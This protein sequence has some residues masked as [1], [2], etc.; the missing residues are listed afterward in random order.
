MPCR[1]VGNHCK[2]L[3]QYTLV[4]SAGERRLIEHAEENSKNNWILEGE[5]W[6]V[7]SIYSD[8]KYCELD[9]KVSLNSSEINIMN[10]KDKSLH[11][12]C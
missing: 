3:R 1:A 10:I 9:C 11:K 12:L 6:F 7:Q 4:L 2:K 5:K 8:N